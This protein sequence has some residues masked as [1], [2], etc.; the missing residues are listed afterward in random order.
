MVLTMSMRGVLAQGSFD[1]DTI[2]LNKA[3]A[4]QNSRSQ[5]RQVARHI[6]AWGLQVLLPAKFSDCHG[7][8]FLRPMMAHS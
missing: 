7:F 3:Y 2:S 6:A 4:S 1:V 5:I 8:S